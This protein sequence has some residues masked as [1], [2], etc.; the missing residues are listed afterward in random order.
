MLKFIDEKSRES[1]KSPVVKYLL[2]GYLLICL[3]M[4]VLIR[5]TCES[6][7]DRELIRMESVAY[8]IEAGFANT[9]DYTESVLNYVNRRISVA[10]KNKDQIN[11][12]LKEFNSSESDFSL[13]RDLMSTGMFYWIEANKMLTISSAYGV[14]K[15]P[16][17]VSSRDYLRQTENRQWKIF[18]GSPTTGVIS[19]QFIIPAAV[20]VADVDGNYIGT[21]VISFKVEELMVRFAKL[22]QR[23]RAEFAI[24]DSQN[25]IVMESTP[26]MFSEDHSL[27][28]E[29]RNTAA[30]KNNPVISNFSLFSPSGN[31]AILRSFEKYPYKVVVSFQNGKV[32]S[33]MIRELWPYL[34]K[35]LIL[36][37]FF[38]MGFYLIR[39]VRHR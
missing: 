27:M 6:Y 3:A 36:T 19:G 31:Y 22:S 15:I 12:I 33:R 10:H 8:D 4:V 35:F 24:L 23:N 39:S 14:V 17:D 21:M 9:L 37:S 7:L 16:V 5:R 34:I 38:G 29:V 25:K 11:K 20:G 30:E 13:I 18:V 1:G 26:G 28:N 2:M 32:A